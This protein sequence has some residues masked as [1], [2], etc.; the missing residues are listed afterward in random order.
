MYLNIS[1]QPVKIGKYPFHLLSPMIMKQ[2]GR[3]LFYPFGRAI[4]GESAPQRLIRQPKRAKNP[5]IE[6]IL[7]EIREI[8]LLCIICCYT[9]PPHKTLPGLKPMF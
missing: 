9:Q 8:K 1:T 5:P 2:P 6:P 4:R 7:E 3:I